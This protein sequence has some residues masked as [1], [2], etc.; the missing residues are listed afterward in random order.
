MR[1]VTS[2]CRRNAPT[3]V[4]TTWLT[5]T[6]CCWITAK[7][8]RG[9][10]RVWL[11][12]S[13]GVPHCLVCPSGVHVGGDSDQPGG[14]QT[15]PQSVSGEWTAVHGHPPGTQL[16]VTFGLLFLARFTFSTCAPKKPSSRGSCAWWG[17]GTS[18][19][20]SPA[21]STPGG[22]SKPRPLRLHALQRTH[23]R[24]PRP[25]C[26]PARLTVKDWTQNVPFY[27]CKRVKADGV[28]NEEDFSKTREPSDIS[29]H[30]AASSRL[31]LLVHR[32]VWLRPPL[33][34]RPV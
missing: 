26:S 27:F 29:T 33:C 34:H 25:L 13:N 18:R 24:M 14:D 2:L 9:V 22:P 1:K 21:A 17:R 6:S 15:Q 19:T 12:L 8:W 5:T 16:L 11:L 28:K 10:E 23:L 3:S 30:C 31:L 4:R 20:A 32:L 7:R